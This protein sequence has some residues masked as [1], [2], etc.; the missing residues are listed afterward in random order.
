MFE[1]GVECENNGNYDDAVDIYNLLLD[2]YKKVA[3][4]DKQLIEQAEKRLR[5]LRVKLKEQNSFAHKLEYSW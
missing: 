3:F 2:E 1:E 4:R 5:T